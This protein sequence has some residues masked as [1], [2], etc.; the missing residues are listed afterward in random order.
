[1]AQ[2]IWATVSNLLRSIR[3]NEWLWA[4]CSG[5]SCQ[6]SNREWIPQVANDKWATVSSLLRL[7]MIDE[8]MSKL[9]FFSEQ[10]AHLLFCS[11]KTSDALNKIWLKCF[12]GIFYVGFLKKTSD[13]LLSSFL[14]SD[15]EW[16]EQIAQ[17]AHQKWV[18]MS[19]L[20]R[21]LTKNERIA[22]KFFFSKSL[23]R[24]FFSKKRVICS[25]NRWAHSQPWKSVMLS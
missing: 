22:V 8:R 13:L 3:T 21:S 25:E 15:N 18:T 19:D 11:Q 5:R 7:L 12:F 2:I 10:I 9:L 16:Y 24:L 1:M 6:M 14:L 17:V 4:N 20:F 23:I